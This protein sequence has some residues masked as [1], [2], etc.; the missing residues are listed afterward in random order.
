MVIHFLTILKLFLLRRPYSFRSEVKFLLKYAYL[1]DTL[2]SDLLGWSRVIGAAI[3]TGF[4]AGFFAGF[5]MIL[6]YFGAGADYGATATIDIGWGTGATAAAGMA[7]LVMATICCKVLISMGSVGW[8]ISF[9]M[10]CSN[11]RIA[12][13][14]TSAKSF[15]WLATCEIRLPFM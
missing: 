9:C 10:R 14:I 8:Y 6:T 7:I 4:F 2:I 5:L 11:L 3:F 12:P 15:F 13:S 1:W